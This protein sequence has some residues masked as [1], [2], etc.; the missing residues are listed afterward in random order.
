MLVLAEAT[1]PATVLGGTP[2]ILPVI[3]S[4]DLPLIP[5][6]VQ[7]RGPFPVLLDTGAAYTLLDKEKAEV[8]GIRSNTAKYGKLRAEGISGAFT[9]NVAEQVSLGVAKTRY[10][11]PVIFV[12][13]VPQRFVVPVFGILGRDILNDYAMTFDGPRAELALSRY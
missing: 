1:D 12:T 11:R 3:W 4:R 6:M 7:G 2:A 10:D 13:E 9:S 8:L 5:V